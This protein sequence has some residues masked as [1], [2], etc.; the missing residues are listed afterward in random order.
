MPPSPR[1]IWRLAPAFVGVWVLACHADSVLVGTDDL[2]PVLEEEFYP[3]EPQ[4]EPGEEIPEL[5]EEELDGGEEPELPWGQPDSG[6]RDAG[7]PP[8]SDPDP[9][10]TGPPPPTLEVLVNNVENLEL[11]SERC[12]GDWKD[13]YSWLKV[14]GRV[15]DLFLVQQIES[16]AQLNTLMSHMKAVFGKDFDGVISEANPHPMLSPC[17]PD[18]AKQTNAIIFRTARLTKVGDKRVWRSWRSNGTGCYRDGLARTR[19]VM[20]RFYDKAAK[21]HVTV[22]SIHWSTSQGNGADP[23][24]ALKNAKETDEY[25]KLPAYQADLSIFGG[26][27]NE[28][29]ET[30]SSY[31][32][33]Y[34]ATNRALG[35]ALKY[36]DPIYAACAV[37]SGSLRGC[38][39]GNWTIGQKAR[40]DFLF[41]KTKNNGVA[42]M[43]RAHTISFGEADAANKQLTGSDAAPN[44]SDH[45]AVISRIGY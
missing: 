11:P 28:S 20:Q 23:A 35:G 15:P 31:K 44:Y 38:L 40:I 1:R 4:E 7:I 36:R 45:R 5:P 33:W 12:A 22:A 8:D 21:R 24:C 42:P 25:L 32:P 13:L 41:A 2:D 17:G 37:G 29:S 16:Q 6:T 18:K 19:P 14:Q 43:A 39:D 27:T 34:R 10:P 26:D 30:A 3:E 9:D